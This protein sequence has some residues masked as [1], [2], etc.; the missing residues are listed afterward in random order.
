[1]T[2]RKQ[3]EKPGSQGDSPSVIRLDVEFTFDS[4]LLH[5]IAIKGASVTRNSVKQ[6]LK[7]WKKQGLIVQ[8]ETG[9]FKKVATVS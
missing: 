5:S 7:N 1:M 2:T 8:T 9:R 4:A 3:Y 6:M